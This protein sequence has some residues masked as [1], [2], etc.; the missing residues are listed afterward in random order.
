M[1]A[2]DSP[3]P[4]RL[5]LPPTASGVTRGRSLPGAAPNGCKIVLN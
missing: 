3:T 5:S 2:G 4:Y 1:M